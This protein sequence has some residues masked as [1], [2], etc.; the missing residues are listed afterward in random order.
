MQ[1]ALNA[2]QPF[3]SR[4]SR[5]ETTLPAPRWAIEREVGIGAKTEFFSKL[6]DVPPRSIAWDERESLLEFPNGSIRPFAEQRIGPS[7]YHVSIVK[8][9]SSQ[10][11]S[12]YF[13]PSFYSDAGSGRF[14]L[15]ADYEVF[16]PYMIEMVILRAGFS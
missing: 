16:V 9:L 14:E 15:D 3:A 6:L 2:D 12:R 13:A 11:D 7:S 5:R 8:P 1:S 10:T 4:S